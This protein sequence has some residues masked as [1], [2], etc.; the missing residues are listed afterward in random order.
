V[1]RQLIEDLRAL[2]PLDRS[3]EGMRAL[4][5][6]GA[7]AWRGDMRLPLRAGG[8]TRTCAYRDEIF[9][10][11]LLNWAP[12]STSA[13][14]DHGDQH[15]WM[16][17][18]AGCLDVEDYRR[19]DSGMVHGYAFVAAHGSRSLEPGAMDLRA[20]RFALHRVSA[21]ADRSALSL[22]V[23][24]APLRRFLVYDER[25]YTCEAAYGAYDEILADE[26]LR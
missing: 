21:R 19:L 4:L 9:E 6:A 25:A 24:S 8:Y 2:A 16:I 13:I 7:H 14:H 18:L 23:Y 15:C 12:G 22:H 10:V 1:L 20:G 17:V 26:A 5:A 11:V 3:A